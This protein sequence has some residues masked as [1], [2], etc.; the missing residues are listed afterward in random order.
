MREELGDIYKREIGTL[1][2]VA[3]SLRAQGIDP[4]TE[5]GMKST[6]MKAVTS[7]PKPPPTP[8]QQQMAAKMEAAGKKYR[9]QNNIGPLRARG[10]VGMG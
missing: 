10:M 1:K 5:K 7:G 4:K 2:K 8:Q 9:Q 3:E 6:A